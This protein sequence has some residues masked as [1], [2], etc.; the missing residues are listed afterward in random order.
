M[1]Q[2]CTWPIRQSVRGDAIA[3][4]EARTT[5]T[6]AFLILRRSAPPR[7][8]RTPP[9]METLA[10]SGTVSSAESKLAAPLCPAPRSIDA[11]SVKEVSPANVAPLVLPLYGVV[12]NV[13]NEPI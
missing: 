11:S 9:S 6:Y 10:G 4:H 2:V 3:S 1:G 5:E 7:M 8:S 13:K 12:W